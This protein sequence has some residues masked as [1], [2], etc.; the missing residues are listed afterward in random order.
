MGV[1]DGFIGRAPAE[2]RLKDVVPATLESMNLSELRRLGRTLASAALVDMRAFADRPVGATELAVLDCLRI[3]DR[4][5][6]G[7]IARRS[8]F[9]Q[10]RVSAVVAELAER[11]LVTIAPDPR[12]RRRSLVTMTPAAR[13]L[14]GEGPTFD[15]TATL[16]R[17]LAKAPADRAE[18]II[19]MLEDLARFVEPQAAAYRSRTGGSR[20][21]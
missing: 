18:E 20:G 16:R 1:G 13:E 6:V 9:V 12:D 3:Q 8:G 2:I 14:L 4:L 7:E 19:D 10:S 11:G 21:A 17:L 5:T 15:A